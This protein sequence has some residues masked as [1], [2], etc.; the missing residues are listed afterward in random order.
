MEKLIVLGTGYALA[1]NCYNTC[2]VLKKENEKEYLLV[3]GGGGNQILKILKD[4]KIEL[5]EIKNIVVTHA[6]TDHILGMIWII[7]KIAQMMLKG[8]YNSNVNIYCHKELMEKIKTICYLTLQAKQTNLFSNRIIFV[9]VKDGQEI[10]IM[11]QRFTFFDIKSTK[12]KQFGFQINQKNGNKITCLGDEPLNI[13]CEKY[14]KDSYFLFSEAFCMDKDKEIYKPY[15]K[16]H[17]TAK[18][19]AIIA[20]RL[21]VKNLVLWHTEDDDLENRKENYTKEA[22]EHYNG[23]VFVPDDLEEIEIK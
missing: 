12:E 11:N 5:C 6:H 22:K 4:K 16:H 17:S 10:E 15:E 2:F 3:D 13:E 8:K 19:A 1:E 20:E 21:N 7:R 14:A 9:E 23:N 18:D